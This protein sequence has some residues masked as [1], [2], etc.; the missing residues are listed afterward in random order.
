MV[1]GRKRRGVVGLNGG[2]YGATGGDFSLILTL[3]VVLSMYTIS[4]V[5][6]GMFTTASSKRGVCV[7]LAGG[8]R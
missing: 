2:L 5:S 7:G 8:G 1:N 3:A 6:L 4:N